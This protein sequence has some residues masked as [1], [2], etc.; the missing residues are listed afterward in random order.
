MNNQSVAII[1]LNYNGWKDTIECLESL[2]QINYYNYDIIL[3]DNNSKDKSLEKIREYC[4]GELNV[5]SPFFNYTSE[6]KPINVLELVEDELKTK[7]SNKFNNFPSNKKLTIIKNSENS[8]FSK[9]NNIGIKFALKSLNSDYIFLL[10]NDTVIGRD[11]LLNLVKLGES[12]DKIGVIGPKIYYYN[13]KGKSNIIES[14]G[15]KIKFIKFPGYF[16]INQGINDNK[17]TLNGSI[18]CEWTSGAAM[19]LK[20]KK[21]PIKILDENYFFGCEDLDLCIKLR[22]KGYIT[23]VS[24]NSNLWHKVGVSREKEFYNNQ[25]GI[26]DLLKGRAKLTKTNLKFLKI[27][28]TYYYYFLPLYSLYILKSYFYHILIKIKY[29]IHVRD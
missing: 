20:I 23:T 5:Q 21:I 9:G 7:I 28:N 14:T 8:G 1:I 12:N 11:S 3:V 17:S 24:L 26:I 18:E 6:N 29:N 13:Y 22:K 4:R 16:P 27:H 10:N 25:K 2:Y 19:L 15:G